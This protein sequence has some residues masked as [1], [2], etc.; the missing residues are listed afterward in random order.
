M[1]PFHP[2]P[3]PPA[4]PVSRSTDQSWTG[5]LRRLMEANERD[6]LDAAGWIVH[7]YSAA[8][9]VPIKQVMDRLR[10]HWFAGTRRLH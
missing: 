1:T 6:D 8:I 9:G 3:F 7:E 2:L 10:T 5:F 4:Q